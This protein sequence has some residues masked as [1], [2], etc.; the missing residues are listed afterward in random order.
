MALLPLALSLR[1][2]RRKLLID[3]LPT[4][5]TS[6]VF[7]GTVELEGTAESEAP[8]KG[9]LSGR[10]CVYYSYTVNER[11]SRQV[12]ETTTDGQGRTQTRT[13]TET[14]WRTIERGDSERS[15]FYLKD[16]RGAI[17][18]LPQ[19]AS[20]EAEVTFS[21]TAGPGHPMYWWCKAPE[22]ADS[23]H[24]RSYTEHAIPMH[25]RLYVVG[26]A[27][28][29]ADIVA[30]EIAAHEG[31]EMFLVSMRPQAKV[32]AGLRWQFWLLGLAGYAV[33]AVVMHWLDTR[34]RSLDFAPA[35]YGIAALA[36]LGA[37]LAGWTWMCFNSLVALRQRV[38]Q[39]WANIDV[40]LKRRADLIPGI[41]RL[42]AGA[43]EHEATVQTQ[44]AAL[45]SQAQATAPGQPGPDPASVAAPIHVLVEAY[46][47]LRTN[48]LF[49]RLQK[50][51][52]DTEDRIAL[53]RAYFNDIAAFYNTRLESFP[54]G[55]VAKL[56]GM[57][58]RPLME[59][60]G[61]ERAAPGVKLA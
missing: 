11:Y 45:R 57:R 42:V 54:D 25:A 59:A 48:A 44:V 55:L 29:R 52:A 10:P 32:S 9:R 6:G 8:L 27:R 43:R 15:P 13:K 16:D 49:L 21:Q 60:A 24:V 38:A 19:G 4:S 23:D 47:E 20:V 30:A 56:G 22:I 7:I 61:F 36:Y 40:E 46:P 1:A 17:R 2:A 12:T 41:V 35:Q 5:K 34:S 28:Q 51:L 50:Q 39:G 26:H 18:V 3:N 53:A 58:P 37:W 33:I 14:G 31:E